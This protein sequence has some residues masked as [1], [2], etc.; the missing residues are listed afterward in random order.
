MKHKEIPLPE[1]F[2]AENTDKVKENVLNLAKNNF[3]D[4]TLNFAQIKSI[5]TAGIGLLLIIRKHVEQNNGSLSFENIPSD[6]KEFME[7][8]NII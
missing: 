8:L 1:S 3:F 6:I 2:C 7:E 5:D 4:I